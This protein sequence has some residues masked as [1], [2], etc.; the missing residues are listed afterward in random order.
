[1][2]QNRFRPLV[3]SPPHEELAVILRR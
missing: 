3:R 2:R 1:V